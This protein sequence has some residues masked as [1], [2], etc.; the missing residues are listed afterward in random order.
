METVTIK[1]RRS[2][3][4]RLKAAHATEIGQSKKVISFMEFTER[5]VVRGL[6]KKAT[7][8]REAG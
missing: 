7:R 4:D 8:K 3:H 2:T 5:V 6:R 1:V